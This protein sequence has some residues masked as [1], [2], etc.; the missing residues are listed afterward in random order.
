MENWKISWLWVI[1]K[2]ITIA[3]FKRSG[4]Q[5]YWE[6]DNSSHQV[7]IWLFGSNTL[8]LNY[9]AERELFG[10]MEIEK[11]DNFVWSFLTFNN[12]SDYSGALA[13]GRVFVI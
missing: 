5:L 2:A 7:C 6:L 9:D 10:Q 8:Q 11:Y 13:V 4:I 3:I 12:W 1:F